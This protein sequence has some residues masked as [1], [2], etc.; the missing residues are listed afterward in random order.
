MNE[1]MFLVCIGM[2]IIKKNYSRNKMYEDNYLLVIPF[3]GDGNGK[4]LNFEEIT[5]EAAVKSTPYNFGC[6]FNNSS[7]NFGGQTNQFECYNCM[8]KLYSKCDSQRK[9][10]Y[11]HCIRYD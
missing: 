3:V 9:K 2:N 6:I 1:N 7:M 11:A 10:F 8:N 4:Y 5:T